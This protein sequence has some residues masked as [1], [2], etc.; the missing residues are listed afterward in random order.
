MPVAMPGCSLAVSNWWDQGIHLRVY[1]Q[2]P[3]LALREHC[4]DDHWQVGEY[5]ETV[6]I[7]SNSC[8]LLTRYRQL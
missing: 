4:Y 6:P 7:Q 8:A 1:Y 2:S 5:Y 3:D